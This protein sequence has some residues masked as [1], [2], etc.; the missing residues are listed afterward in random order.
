MNKF[1]VIA[2]IAIC[3]FQNGKA[4]LRLTEITGKYN[5]YQTTWA[6]TKLQ[7]VLNQEKFTPGDTIFFKAYFLKEDLTR[8]RGKQLVEAHLVNDQGLSSIHLKFH[9][10]NGLGFNQLV[11]PD[12]LKAGIYY[13]TAYN[14]WIRNF[15][16]AWFF[17]KKITIVKKMEVAESQDKFLRAVPEGGKLIAGVSNKL[18][19]Y[20]HQAGAIIQL[21]EGTGQEVSRVTT[22]NSGTASINFTPAEGIRYTAHMVDESIHTDLPAVEQDGVG[23]QLIGGS[24]EQVTLTLTSPAGSMYHGKEL[25]V[26]IT[27]RGK[28]LYTSTVKH[29]IRDSVQVMTSDYPD[30]LMKISLL[31]ATGNVLATR[32]FYHHRDEVIVRLQ[33]D[34]QIYGT[35]EKVKM[36]ISITDVTGKPMAGEFSIRAI[37]AGLFEPTSNTL[38]EELNIRSELKLVDLPKNKNEHWKQSLDN[39]QIINTEALPWAAMLSGPSTAP[40]YAYS[41]V[42]EKKGKA[43]DG[44]TNLPLPDYTQILFYLQKDQTYYQTFTMDNGRVALTLQDFY[45][46][47]EFFYLAKIRYGDEINNVKV[48]WEKD[49]IPLPSAPLS[50]ELEN[51]DRYATFIKRKQLIDQSFEV[52]SKPKGVSNTAQDFHDD[53]M[54]ADITVHLEDY[55]VFPTMHDVIKEVVS[56]MYSRKSKNGDIVRIDLLPPLMGSSNP[57]YII[58]GF[59]TKNTEYFMS[60]KPS[61]LKTL[62]VVNN[63]QKL[64]PTGLLGQFGI[65]IVESKL[66]NLREPLTSD[67]KR[68]NGLQL[69]VK[70]KEVNPEKMNPGAPEFRSTIY[71]NPSIKTDESGKALVEFM[72]SD[73][74]GA[75]NVMIDGITNGLQPFSSIAELKVEIKKSGQ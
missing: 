16:P 10:H 60:L 34:Q 67:N 30:G 41:N 22:D 54:D 9:V 59:A 70:F 32:D 31:D 23:L 44:N 8:I 7:L 40:P 45:G 28:V 73:D 57:V 25:Y 43:L 24:N 14:N 21:K 36:E 71:W 33:P 58:D 53:L 27:S 20:A 42:I 75:I 66:G 56:G 55:V 1:L 72:V 3:I 52:H 51:E 49:S 47:D 4:Q 62:K 18:A 26:V 15:D 39:I 2:L 69:P 29:T 74:V 46:E 68:I 19:V 63:P 6:R 11:I 61:G 13:L 12:T 5:A 50:S 48:I 17:K 65:V 37:N 64:I 35:R 38:Q